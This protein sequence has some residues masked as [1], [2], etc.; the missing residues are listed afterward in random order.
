M[1]ANWR[2]PKNGLGRVFHLKLASFAV[3]KE[4]HGA[5]KR[6]FLK[7]KIRP[8][9]CPGSISLT[10]ARAC[11]VKIISSK[12]LSWLSSSVSST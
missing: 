10:M 4:V 3:I 9:L 6:P 11:F 7:L 5:N 8:R 2:K 12:N 1:K